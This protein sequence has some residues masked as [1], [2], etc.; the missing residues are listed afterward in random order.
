VES[1]ACGDPLGGVE[2]VCVP[3]SPYCVRTRSTWAADTPE[4]SAAIS[5]SV[6]VGFSSAMVRICFC[7]TD[8]GRVEW[9]SVSVMWK[10]GTRLVVNCS[11]TLA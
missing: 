6:A 3:G 11:V 5:A 2:V 10:A 7:R 4:M 1:D 9:A 8:F